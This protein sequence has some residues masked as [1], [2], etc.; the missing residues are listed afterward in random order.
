[1]KKHPAKI[2][3]AFAAIMAA[4]TLSISAQ[5]QCTITMSGSDQ[6]VIDGYGFASTW[7]G[8]MSSAQA[9]TFFGT[10]S[11]QLG[12]TL[13]RVDIDPTS[14][15]STEA[16]NSS[17]A[18]SYGAKVLGTPWTPPASMKSNDSLVG[19]SLNTSQYGAYATFLNGAASSANLNLDYVSMQNEPD[20]NVSYDSCSWTGSQMETW[21]Q[22]NAPTVG[23]PI[24]MPESE[25][26]NTSYSDPTLN[27]STACNNITIIAG[28]LYGGGP[29]VYSNALNHNKH[30]WMTEHY[31]NGTDIGTCMTIAKEV[32]DCMNDQMSAYI[33]WYGYYSGAS[34]DLV[35]GS[36][37]LLNGYMI[38]QFS[39]WVR[40]GSTRV[41][42]TYNPQSNVYVTAYRVNGNCM[43]VAL[44]TGTSSVNQQFIINNG[45]AATM[46]GYR[47]SSSQNMADI[48]SSTVSSGNF[49]ASLP[50][51]SVTTFVQTS[52]G[53]GGG[54]SG[55]STNTWYNIQNRTSGL[56]VN[57]TGS[58]TSGAYM[59]QWAAG[60]SPNLCWELL[61][62]GSG[63]YNIEN[64]TS[65]MYLDGGGY[66]TNNAPV[67][68]WSAGSSTNLRW[69]LSSVG[70]GYYNIINETSGLYLNGGGLTTNGAPLTQWSAVSSYNL[71]WQFVNP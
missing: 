19:G 50:G 63:Y 35:S 11:G 56:V 16:A 4:G 6:Q 3:R 40:P 67:K 47:S 30:V 27:N 29:F 38:G 51:Q 28:H 68:Q 22:N 60:T 17:M 10:G 26:F 64:E 41:S 2:I 9:A 46:E 58:T 23:K 25:A 61:T 15:F 21:C 39:K 69:S 48:G 43:I 52:S 18:H 53:S 49:T 59:Q 32:S 37:P 54:G 5:A 1:M 70:S 44:N 8:E 24:V 7:S 57:N 66:T 12:F 31:Y 62:V 34:C 14:S 45:N 13:L 65:S 42:A 20:A 33:W 71:Q 55:L 36:T